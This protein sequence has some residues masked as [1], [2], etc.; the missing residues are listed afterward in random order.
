MGGVLAKAVVRAIDD[1]AA[2][3]LTTCHVKHNC[4]AGEG[5]WD[6]VRRLHSSHDG[7]GNFKGKNIYFYLY[8][9]TFF[10]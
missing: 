2:Y 10:I 1:E 3:E 9:Y 4:R 7:G 8:N 5:G 6:S